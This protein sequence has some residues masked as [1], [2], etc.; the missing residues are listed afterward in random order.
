MAQHD[1]L[2]SAKTLCVAVAGGVNVDSGE[3]H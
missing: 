2:V 3:Q 1:A